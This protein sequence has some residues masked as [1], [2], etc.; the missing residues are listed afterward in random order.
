MKAKKDLEALP[1]VNGKKVFCRVDFNVP[2]RDGTVVDDNRIAASLP[3]LRWLAEHGARTIL[4]SHLGRPKGKANPQF[5]L[6]PVAHRLAEL[7]GKQVA[8]ATD[9]VGPEAERAA[10]SLHSGEFL[11]LENLRFHAGEEAN[12]PE[13]ARRLARLG[14]CYVNDAFGSAHR[15]HAS[16]AGVPAILRPAVAGFLMQAELLHLG[17]LLQS[18]APPFLAILGG[19]KVSDKIDL[20]ENL[21]PRV[22]GFLIGGAMAYTFLQAEGAE[23]GA[24]RV[25]SDK[26]DLARSILD[27]ARSAGKRFLLPVDHVVAVGGNDAETRVTSGPQ[28]D[29]GDSGMDIGPKTVDR[30]VREIQGAKTLLWNGPLGR[31]EVPAFASGS[32][33]VAEAVAG[34]GGSSIVGGGDTAAAVKAFGVQHRMT[35]VSTGGGASLEFLSGLALPGVEALDASA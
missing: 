19:A 25:E 21:L 5:S 34:F 2:T 18:P 17:S 27:R 14:D 7:L 23:V 1:D 24:S 8:F 4:A 11:L 13:F 33:A 22:D 31:F 15:A 32:H 26:V 29:G 35:H 12:D 10:D 9:C 16:T 20:V 28:I 3:T 6:R 30:F